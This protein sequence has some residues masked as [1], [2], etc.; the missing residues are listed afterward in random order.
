MKTSQIMKE[1]ILEKCK[2]RDEAIIVCSNSNQFF[3]HDIT[4]GGDENYTSIF[5]FKDGSEL[6]IDTENYVY[7]EEDKELEKN[8]NW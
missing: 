5:I 1:E 4:Q 6:R 7:T 2:Y 8:K 3:A